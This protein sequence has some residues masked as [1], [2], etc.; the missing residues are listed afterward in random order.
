MQ[1]IKEALR[2]LMGFA[3]PSGF[4]SSSTADQVTAQDSS[5]SIPPN[6]TAIITG[7]TSGIGAE[8]ARVLAKRGLRLIIPARD[9]KR[10]AEVRERIRRESPTAEIVVIEMDLS[11]IASIRRFCARFLA[12][13]LPLNILIN[14][15]GKFCR[16]PQF[17]DDKY[18]MT[19]ATNY[20]GHFILTETLIEKMVETARET[21]IE[22]RIINVSSIIHKWVKRD[23]FRLS[24]ML[25]PKDYNATTAYAQSKLANIMHAKEIARQLKVFLMHCETDCIFFLTSRLL[26][27]PSQ[28]ASTTCYVA[29]NPQVQGISGKYFVDCNESSCSSLADDEIAAQNLWKETRTLVRRLISKP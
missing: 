13:G 23:G 6:L 16:R 24:N 25:K 17:T 29:L 4:G 1:S 26:K 5:H 28:G 10:A 18:E 8:T 9:V 3:G 21:G 15:A 27:T 22:G 20:L 12:L 7:A 14:N 2:Y 11:S 19:F